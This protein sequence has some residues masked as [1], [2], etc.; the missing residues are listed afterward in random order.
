MKY[1]NERKKVDSFLKNQ[2]IV[3]KGFDPINIE[4]GINWNYK[5]KNN[6][7][8]YQTY[9]HSLGIVTDLLKISIEDDNPKL[10]KY[11]QNIIINWVDKNPIDISKYS[12]KEHPVSSRINN[13][14]EFQEKA[15]K[16]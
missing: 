3:R 10:L 14:I 1:S 11:A 6:A 15:I 5:H 7:N 8:T 2:L 13:I 9:L 4:S 16:H 12:W